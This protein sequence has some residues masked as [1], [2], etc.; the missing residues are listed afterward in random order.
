MIVT[1]DILVMLSNRAEVQVL[2]SNEICDATTST[3]VL[4]TLSCESRVDEMVRKAVAAG[5]TTYNK[6]PEHFQRPRNRV[7]LFHAVTVD[8]GYFDQS[9]SLRRFLKFSRLSPTDYINRHKRF[10]E[11]N[12][13]V[14]RDH[15]PHS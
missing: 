4:V 13:H 14:Q 15:L 12:I 5:G 9:H 2:Y 1:D 6:S 10:I 11:P 7:M 3:E 8:F